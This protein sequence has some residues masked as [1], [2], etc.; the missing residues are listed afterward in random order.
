MDI[1]TE[2]NNFFENG[3]EYIDAKFDLMVLNSAEKAALI[4]AKLTSGVLILSF[5]FMIVLLIS[6][7]AALLL[8]QWLGNAALG[9][10]ILAALLALVMYVAIT[11]SKKI[12]QK[13]VLNIVAE[14]IKK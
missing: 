12:I 4:V 11:Q 6:I 8:G 5:M 7:G 9:F 3:K 14:T 2:A 1:K 10:F 13:S